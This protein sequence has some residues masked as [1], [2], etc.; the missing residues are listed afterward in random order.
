MYHSH[1]H[2]KTQARRGAIKA[3]VALEN[4]D[5]PL[6]S[7]LSE[8]NLPATRRAS[9]ANLFPVSAARARASTTRLSRC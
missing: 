3:L 7:A 5:V 4:S 2:P 9:R 8:L 1:M 6:A